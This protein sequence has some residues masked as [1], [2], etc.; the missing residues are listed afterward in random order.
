MKVKITRF[1]YI[2]ATLI[3]K[4]RIKETPTIKTKKKLPKFS[5]K[6]DC[7]LRSSERN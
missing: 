6:I 2:C 7:K 4:K 3:R 5:I 1:S